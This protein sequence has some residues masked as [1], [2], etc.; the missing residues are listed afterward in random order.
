MH[1]F[2]GKIPLSLPQEFLS[3][4]SFL[5]SLVLKLLSHGLSLGIS[6]HMGGKRGERCLSSDV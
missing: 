3:S 5:F 6:A 1:N 4:F 2:V